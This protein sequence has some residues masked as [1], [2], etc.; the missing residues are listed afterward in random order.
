MEPYQ[1]HVVQA[2]S[3]NCFVYSSGLLHDYSSLTA[4]L[5]DTPR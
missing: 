5:A 3:D 1:Q 2:K 4:S